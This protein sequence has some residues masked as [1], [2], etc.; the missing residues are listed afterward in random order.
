MT[1][2]EQ[3]EWALSHLKLMRLKT[4]VQIDKRALGIAIEEVEARL[5][6]I[7]SAPDSDPRK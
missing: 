3:M 5:I 2:K 6:D 7:R 1:E 4:K